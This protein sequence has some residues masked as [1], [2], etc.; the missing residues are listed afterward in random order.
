M[1]DTFNFS[2]D[3]KLQYP[4]HQYDFQSFDFAFNDKYKLF[5]ISAL[6]G[7]RR[8]YIY[9]VAIQTSTAA[10]TASS[11]TA[12]QCAAV[13]RYYYTAATTVSSILQCADFTRYYYTAATTVS[14]ILQCADFTRYCYTA[15]TNSV[16]HTTSHFAAVKI[17]FYQ[18]AKGQLLKVVYS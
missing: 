10:T 12:L 9:C 15:A 6:I 14:S 16:Q 18:W 13:T 11:A 17:E 2:S 1:Q 8:P 3:Q 5:C 4:L 7:N